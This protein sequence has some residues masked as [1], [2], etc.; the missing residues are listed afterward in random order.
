MV[1]LELYDHCP[2]HIPINVVGLDSFLN[3]LIYIG[4]YGWIL[5]ISIKCAKLLAKFHLGHFDQKL[6]VQYDTSA[7]HQY[8]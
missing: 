5:F 3:S 2:I 7:S 8:G 4:L 6:W 1:E